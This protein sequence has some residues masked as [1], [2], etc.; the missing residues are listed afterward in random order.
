MLAHHEP[1]R[2]RAELSPAVKRQA[3]RALGHLAIPAL[4]LVTLTGFYW[5]ITLTRQFDW[6][7]GPDL[8]EQVLPWFDVQAREWHAHRFPLWDPAMWA[9][10]PL[11]GQAQPGAVYPLNWLLFLMP[12]HRGHISMDAL[13]WYFVVI[14]FMAALFC[15]WLCRDLGCSRAASFIGGLAFAL[16]GILGTTGWP[17][18]ANGMVWIPLV[19]LFLLRAARGRSVL[20]N[21]AL[22]GAF[23]GISFLS[24]HHQAPTF[25][26][27]AFLGVWLYLIFRRGPR[28][29][30]QMVRAAALA[31]LFVGLCGAMQILPAMEYGRLAKRWAGASDA[32][33]WNQPVPY[34]VHAQYDL[35]PFSLLGTVFPGVKRHYDPYVGVVALAL[36]IL[37]IATFWRE[38]RA[39][40]V[41]AVGL[42][43]IVYALGANSVF[44][45]FL[46]AVVPG[47]EKARSP[48]AAVVLFA[49]GIAVLA[50]FGFDRL[51]SPEPSPWPRRI[52]LGALG[53]GGV[54]IVIVQAVLF[55]HELKF[56]TDDRVILTAFIALGLA[57]LFY[58]CR[59]QSLS[60][61]AANAL[62][63]MLLLLELGN[64]SG[65]DI[66][67]RTDQGREMWLNHLR[68]NGDIAEFL[69]RQPGHQ[70]IDVAGDAF[71]QNWGAWNGLETRMGWLASVTR[72]VLES[73]F[74]SDRGRMIYGVA[75]TIAAGPP[76]PD[77]GREVFTGAS[78]MKVYQRDDAF[79]RAWAVHNLVRVPSQGAGNVMIGERLHEFRNM[80]VME[81][82]PPKLEACESGHVRLIE[83]LP[84]RVAIEAEMNC[85]GMVVLSDTYFPGWRALVDGQSTPIHEVNG[86]FRG[87]VVPRG[88]HVITM[89]YRPMS[90]ALGALLTLLGVAGAVVAAVRSRKEE[91]RKLSHAV[92]K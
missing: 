12:L 38:S 92:A 65:Y 73:E 66:V 58:C 10:Q 88:K 4:L 45:G 6:V 59:R 23:L 30:V 77:A 40:I 36:A 29:D 26:A 53:F 91:P 22:S 87:V 35:K 7:W 19:F 27:V 11:V 43:A 75:Y 49:F 69:K 32:L 13:A 24:G 71:A 8:A 84:A 57:A 34:Y 63:A 86:A 67:H 60:R 3:R 5:K 9:G 72:N 54:T 83:H 51:S 14:R 20:A 48:S 74:F 33:A 28:P 37:G 41:G 85:T 46:Y 44:H 78:G 2:W 16:S 68:S 70:R 81:T 80:A 61:G 47:L 1:S 42:G 64:N 21:G 50:A 31:L 89:R 79:P 25:T 17:Q 76:P 55:S 15:Y 62:L 82:A 90:L 52:M 18:M 56:P 39:R